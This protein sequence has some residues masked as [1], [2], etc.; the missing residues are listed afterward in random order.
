[1]TSSDRIAIL[2]SLAVIIG[3]AFIAGSIFENMAH[4][5]DEFA[6][7]WQANTIAG[8]DLTLPSPDYSSS[9]LIPFVID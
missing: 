7:I 9:F 8:S 6:Y 2:F 5:E 3:A 4:L 1:M